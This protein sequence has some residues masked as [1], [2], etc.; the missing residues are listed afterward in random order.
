VL[1]LGLWTIQLVAHEWQFALLFTNL[2]WC[3]APQRAQ[4]I[5]RA[6]TSPRWRCWWWR[7]PAGWG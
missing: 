7:A 4:P 5:G 6:L 2:L 3:A 1:L